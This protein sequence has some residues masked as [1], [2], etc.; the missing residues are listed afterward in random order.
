MTI[1]KREVVVVNKAMCRNCGD[2]LESVHRHDFKTCGCG[3]ISVDGGTSYLKRSF[4]NYGDVI[5]LSETYE[6]DYE[7][8]Y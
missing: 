4:K 8:N 3:S 2:V 5:E 7:A 6:E 1:L